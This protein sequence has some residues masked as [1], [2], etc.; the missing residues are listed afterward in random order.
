MAAQTKAD[1]PGDKKANPFAHPDYEVAPENAT[2]PTHTSV[3]SDDEAH[4]HIVGG[5]A[6]DEVSDAQERG[7]KIY[8]SDGGKAFKMFGTGLLA[9]VLP[10][11][12]IAGAAIA[13]A[14][15]MI[16]GC[17]K[18]L[19]GIGK[20]ISVGPE[21][22]YKAGVKPQVKKLKRALGINRREKDK[23]GPISI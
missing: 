2:L 1:Y 3:A 7:S 15:V 14:G 4:Q 18:L 13:S 23:L 5:T 10:P 16:Y 20:G 21:M 8:Q 19:E 11:V 9:I 22:A 12:L 6:A 17:G